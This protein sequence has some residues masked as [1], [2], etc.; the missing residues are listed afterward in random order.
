M[1]RA[2]PL[3]TQMKCCVGTGRSCG[4]DKKILVISAT[5]GPNFDKEVNGTLTSS[6]AVL[7]GRR[8]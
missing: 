3:S 4:A 8:S 6:N 7:G 2:F 5:V 1:H